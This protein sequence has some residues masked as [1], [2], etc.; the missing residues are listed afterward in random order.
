MGGEDPDRSFLTEIKRYGSDNT[1]YL[2]PISFSYSTFSP[3]TTVSAADAIIHSENAPSSVIDSQLV[4]LIDMNRDGL[5]DLLKTDLQGSRHTC[6]FNLGMNRD[7][8][9]LEIEWA[10]PQDVRNDDELALPLHL[11][12]DSV[13]LADMDGDGISDLI[14]KAYSGD[15][16]YHLNQGDGSWADR[17]RMSIQDTA[18]PAPFGDDNVK[19]SDLDFD[20]RMDVVR[21][22]DFNGHDP[23]MH[24]TVLAGSPGSSGPEILKGSPLR[25]FPTP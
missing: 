7:T 25:H 2:P 4:E 17:K 8:S 3:K 24:T 15:V 19:T 6:Y 5:P 22:T 12:E 18:P 23:Y 21:S 13:H 11:T 9:L 20:K 10:D 16:F 1:S 14:D